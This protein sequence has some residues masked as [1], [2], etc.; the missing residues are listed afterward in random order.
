MKVTIAPVSPAVSEDWCRLRQAFWS[1]R[2]EDEHRRVIAD[3][4]VGRIREPA[5]VFLAQS[6]SGVWIGLL[7]LSIRAYAEGCRDSHPAYVE[8]I[9]VVPEF[10]RA[11][12]ATQLLAEAERWSRSRGCT[13]IASDSAP[14]NRSSGGL[15]AKA[16]FRDV[17]LVRCWAKRLE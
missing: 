6:E 14:D 9:Y 16:G 13:E 11:G 12:V 1:S 17:G 7:E 15:H 5:A 10:R 3:F 8:G 4:L 2:T